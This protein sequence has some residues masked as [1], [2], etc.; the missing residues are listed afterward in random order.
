MKLPLRFGYW[1]WDKDA[2]ENRFVEGVEGD[3]YSSRY[4]DSVYDG[5]IDADGKIVIE[6]AG[7]G[8][9]MITVDPELIALLKK[10]GGS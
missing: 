4:G 6:Y 2:H 7:C 9:H 5:A 1:A 10:D 3:D 8:S